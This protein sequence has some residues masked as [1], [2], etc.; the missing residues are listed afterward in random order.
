MG[1]GFRWTVTLTPDEQEAYRWM[2]T[3]TPRDAIVQMDP[4]A[5]GR[6]TWSQLPTFAWRRMAAARPI[7]LMNIPDYAERSQTG[8]QDLRR[9]EC[10]DGSAA[11]A[12]ARHRLRLHRP[13]RTESQPRDGIGEVFQEGRPLHGSVR[14]R[15]HAHLR[16]SAAK[17]LV[18]RVAQCRRAAACCLS[19]DFDTWRPETCRRLYPLS[20]GS[21]PATHK[22][23]ATSHPPIWPF[24]KSTLP[25]DASVEDNQPELAAPGRS[26]EI[27][28]CRVQRTGCSH[29]APSCWAR[30]F[31]I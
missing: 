27:R 11:R 6:E 18:Q 30:R 1:P 4:I 26:P 28:A 5:H 12:R 13:G 15:R 3:E 23:R 2:R 8:A 20:P 21:I 22:H 19:R 31:S 7:S 25:R 14:Q 29:C 9:A 24:H 17:A 10:R 16:R